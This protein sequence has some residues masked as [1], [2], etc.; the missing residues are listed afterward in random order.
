MDSCGLHACIYQLAGNSRSVSVRENAIVVSNDEYTGHKCS[1]MFLWWD[2][3]VIAIEMLVSRHLA[4]SRAIFSNQWLLDAGFFATSTR[5]CGVWQCVWRI[6]CSLS[7][8][9]ELTAKC[10]PQMQLMVNFTWEEFVPTPLPFAQTFQ[11]E[12]YP[13]WVDHCYWIVKQHRLLKCVSVCDD[14]HFTWDGIT[15]CLSICVCSPNN[16][17]TCFDLWWSPIYV[18]WSN[19]LYNNPCLFTL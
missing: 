10:A 13:V 9:A 17:E 16:L 14:I 15:S 7:V 6:H 19:K 8:S 11:P 18:S 12:A 3:M 2:C 5:E 1:S 4:P